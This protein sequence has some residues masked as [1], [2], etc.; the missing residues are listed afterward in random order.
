MIQAGE[1]KQIAS[2]LELRDTQIEKDYVNSWI[3]K[4]INNN[5]YLKEHLIFK[6]GTLLRKVFYP[7]YRLSEDLDF[8]FQKENFDVEIIKIEFSSVCRWVFDESRIRLEM[9]DENIYETGNFNFYI[10]YTGPL[11][12]AGTN[13]S[14]KVDISS[15]ELIINPPGR[16]FLYKVYS[17]LKEE[18]KVL[19]YEIDELISEKMRSLM[20][21]TEP[22]DLYDIWYIFEIESLNIE[23]YIYTFK[24]KARYKGY[25]PDQ[26]VPTLEKKKIIFQKNWEQHLSVQLNDLPDFE[27]VWRGLGKHWRKFTRFIKT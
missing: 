26:F 18:Q 8:T 27:D 16:K 23:N 1:I 21:R 4:G 3:L 11:G 14:I 24:A 12:G 20:Q 17:D 15:T 7:E 6:G 25:D 22:R 10:S 2:R 5:K 9:I 13:K 19:C